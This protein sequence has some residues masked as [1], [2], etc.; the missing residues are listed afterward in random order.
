ML[1]GFY[2]AG[3]GMMAQQR[4]QESLSNNMA[5]AL[6]PGYK[7]DRSTFRAFPEMLIQNIE[8]RQVPTSTGL[9]LPRNHIVGPINSGV[10]MQEDIPLFQQGPIQET[11][12]NTDVALLNGEMPDDT[13]FLFFT[14][15]NGDGDVRYTRNGHFTVDAE[16]YLTT[17]EGFYVLNDEGARIQT[18]TENF[19]V[20]ANGAVI[21]P[22]DNTFLGVVY[23]PNA[24]DFVKEGDNLFNNDGEVAPVDARAA[25]GVSFQI[26]QGQL[27]RSNVDPAQVMTEMTRSYRLFEINQQVVRMF[28]QSMDLAANQ[29]GRLR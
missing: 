26:G 9:K 10:Y 7:Q 5:N 14:V 25:G 18:G 11:H 22:F 12:I 6:T 4:Y 27:E 16:G 2:T 23:H 17:Q 1:R 29:I 13:G 8:S 21:S 28:D 20:M 15:Q 3:A 19:E 24:N